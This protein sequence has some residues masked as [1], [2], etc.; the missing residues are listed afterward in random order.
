MHEG[1]RWI[2]DWGERVAPKPYLLILEWTF[3]LL[4][5][6]SLSLP[7]AGFSQSTITVTSGCTRSGDG[8]GPRRPSAVEGLLLGK[9]RPG[10]AAY[11]G[12]CGLHAAGQG[13]SQASSFFC[14]L[15][16]LNSPV[17]PCCHMPF[18]S[19]WTKSPHTLCS[20]TQLFGL[21]VPLP[22]M[23]GLFNRMFL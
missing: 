9:Q 7:H 6:F 10:A 22:H 19:R 18:S 11:R 13:R 12:R 8:A 17:P 16:P 5:S 1:W 23:H 2:F 14:L 21:T 4:F 20:L 3:F 15:H